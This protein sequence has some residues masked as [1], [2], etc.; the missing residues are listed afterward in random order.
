[1]IIISHYHYFILAKNANKL[2]SN[3]VQVTVRE[4]ADI[5]QSKAILPTQEWQNQQIK[6]FS[7][8]RAIFARHVASVQKPGIPNKKRHKLPSKTNER[9]IYYFEFY[10]LVRERDTFSPLHSKYFQC[11]PLLS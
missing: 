4:K 1:M 11:I 10:K 8:T 2:T 7:E 3:K 6:D 9:G 5:K